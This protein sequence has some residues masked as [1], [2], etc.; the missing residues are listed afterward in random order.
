MGRRQFK[1]GDRVIYTEG[2]ETI[3]GTVIE[4]EY[5]HS[6]LTYGYIHFLG[7]DG[8]PVMGNADMSFRKAPTHNPTK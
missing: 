1:K 5:P 4:Y 6:P 3:I 7:D 8:T 2:G